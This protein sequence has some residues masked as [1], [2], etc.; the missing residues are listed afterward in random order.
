MISVSYAQNPYTALFESPDINGTI[1]LKIYDTGYDPVQNGFSFPNPSDREEFFGVDLNDLT[2]IKYRD[3]IVRHTGHCYGM[4]SLSVEYFLSDVTAG[5]ISRS[6]AMPVIDEIQTEQSFYYIMEYLRPPV[7]VKIPDNKMEYPK[8][9]ERISSGTPAVIGIYTSEND[10]EGH[11]LVVYRIIEYEDMAYLFVYDPNIPDTT[12][13]PKT[14]FCGPVAIYDLN[15]GT[16]YYDNGI[17]FDKLSLD[18]VNSTGVMKGKILM[19]GSFL[20]M[21]GTISAILSARIKS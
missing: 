4:A 2:G 20:L 12:I 21:F 15:S 19:S 14:M 6:D 9:K 13:E 3:E 11:A 1:C 7:G 17:V 8:I 5:D 10:H 18:T 16:F